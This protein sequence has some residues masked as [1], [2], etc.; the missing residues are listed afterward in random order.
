MGILLYIKHDSDLKKIFTKMTF[1][2]IL[3]AVMSV[4]C[5]SAEWP[6]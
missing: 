1:D 2:Q 4:I 5:V 6:Q 3:E